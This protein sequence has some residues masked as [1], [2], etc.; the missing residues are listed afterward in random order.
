[1]SDSARATCSGCKQDFP[2]EDLIAFEGRRIC[3]DCKPDFFAGVREGVSVPGTGTGGVT[4]I[5]E[6]TL[7]AR[8]GL[9]GRWIASA[10]ILLF[11]AVGFVVASGIFL[12]SIG[13]LFEVLDVSAIPLIVVGFWVFAFF[14]ATTTGPAVVGLMRHFLALARGERGGLLETFSSLQGFGRYCGLMGLSLLVCGALAGVILA[15]VVVFVN[16]MFNYEVGDFMYIFLESLLMLVLGVL[17]WIALCGVLGMFYRAARDPDAPL[18]VCVREGFPVLRKKQL[19]LFLMVL[20]I[21]MWVLI[22]AVLL[23]WAWTALFYMIP[24]SGGGVPASVVVTGLVSLAIVGCYV[25]GSLFWLSY[26]ATAV[27]VFCDD[28]QEG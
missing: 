13:M 10:F 23:S 27:M 11:V 1:M 24:A 9:S 12:F 21:G 16:T 25:L 5:A 4:P 3:V 6:L 28:L 18:W 14:F 7:A 8:A 22:P 20:R 2:S 15:L 19:K 17:E 26:A